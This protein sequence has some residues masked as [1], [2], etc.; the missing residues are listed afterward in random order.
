MWLM[1]T[2]HVV[3]Q[4]SSSAERLTLV[5]H[6]HGGI[7]PAGPEDA[8][9]F[10]YF[11]RSLGLAF[12]DLVCVPPERSEFHITGTISTQTSRWLY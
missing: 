10:A 2:I 7:H 11:R 9:G 5:Q 8:R 1:G 6:S 3:T 12:V 4:E